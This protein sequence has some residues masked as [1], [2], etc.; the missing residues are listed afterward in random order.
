MEY[1]NS[2]FSVGNTLYF[3][4]QPVSGYQQV[5]RSDG[6]QMVPVDL[7]SPDQSQ[8]RFIAGINDALYLFEYSR[9]R[10]SLLQGN[11]MVDID[12]ARSRT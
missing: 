7:G 11:S 4:A 6:T 1:F 12:L 5:Y 10:I 2:L 3:K 9:R 8:T